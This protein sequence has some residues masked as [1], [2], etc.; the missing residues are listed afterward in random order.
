MPNKRQ[1]QHYTR[2]E[3]L[4]K[5]DNNNNQN[6]NSN[7][8]LKYLSYKEMSNHHD[9]RNNLNNNDNNETY[10]SPL[11]AHIAK[12]L[13]PIKDKPNSRLTSD[14]NRFISSNMSNSSTISKRNTSPKQHDEIGV[15]GTKYIRVNTLYYSYR[16]IIKTRG[17]L[18]DRGANGGLSGDDA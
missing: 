9:N 16:N 2:H 8:L 7:E 5:Q 3:S 13:S 6:N 17:A 4:H 1:L 18:A 15:N 14:F 10:Q 11:L 12:R